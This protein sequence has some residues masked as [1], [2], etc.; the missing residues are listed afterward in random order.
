MTEESLSI[1][2]A[3]GDMCSITFLVRSR[4]Y[5][6]WELPTS[7][8]ELMNRDSLIL[9]L[10]TIRLMLLL[11]WRMVLLL[12]LILRGLH[13]YVVTIYLL[14]RLMVPGDLPSQDSG[15]AIPSTMAIPLNLYGIRMS[16]RQ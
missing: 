14:C 2:C 16:R 8:S 6:V 4:V 9:V 12:I 3:T 13:G 1:C 11:S 15:N 10:Q 5:R 7:L